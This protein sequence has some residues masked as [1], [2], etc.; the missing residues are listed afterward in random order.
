MLSWGGAEVGR[1]GAEPGWVFGALLAGG[2]GFPEE[3]FTRG[4][5]VTLRY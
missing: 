1:E 4:F 3:V 5:A 2:E